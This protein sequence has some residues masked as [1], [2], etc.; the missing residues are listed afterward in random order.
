MP[1]TEHEFVYK[2]PGLAGGSRPGAHRSRSRGAGMAFAA[3]ARLFDQPDPRRIDLRASLSTLPREW[4]V[5]SSFQLSS[6]TVTA[7]V[8]VSASMHF[9]P[10]RSKLGLV[11]EFLEAL[12]ISA[13]RAGD[14]VALAAFDHEFRQDLYL[15]PRH[16]RGVGFDLAAKIRSCHARAAQADAGRGLADCIER[17]AGRGGLAFVAS[18]FHWP[19]ERVA[20]LLERVADLRVVPLV[21]WHEA[22]IAPPTGN[23]LLSLRDVESQR[24]RRL[25]LRAATRQKWRDNVESR[26][27]QIAAAFGR[28][29]IHP[30][31]VDGSFEAERLSRYFLEHA[32]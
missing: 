17:I 11:A 16:G 3:H 2:I 9:G 21:I 18:D 26:R 10:L 30:F 8:D 20:P 4:R 32:A 12:G 15:P 23:G 25:W 14:G 19:L 22:E 5:R 24:T 27:R 31:H 6:I 13:H 1:D 29:D 7:L 28:G